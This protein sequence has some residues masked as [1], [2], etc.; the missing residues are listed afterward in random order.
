M[1]DDLEVVAAGL[2]DLEGRL[3]AASTEGEE[4]WGRLRHSASAFLSAAEA[5]ASALAAEDPVWVELLRLY[6]AVEGE[7]VA[8]GLEAAQ[9][10]SRRLAAKSNQIEAELGQALADLEALL[11]LATAEI[12]SVGDEVHQRAQSLLELLTSECHPQIAEAVRGLRERTDAVRETLAG[13]LVPPESPAARED[14]SV[15]CPSAVGALLDELT[16]VASK[17]ENLGKTA[18]SLAM[19]GRSELAG[20]RDWLVRGG[21]DAV[22]RVRTVLQAVTELDEVL[23]RRGFG[24]L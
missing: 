14:G 17:V 8:L 6:G 15:A 3:A 1:P 20:E 10:S 21:R 19:E 7:A 11:A 13:A 4:A 9:E 24:G 2:A 18:R 12:E 16:S 23:R 5:Q 22:A